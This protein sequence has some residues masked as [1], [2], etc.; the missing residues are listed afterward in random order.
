M[1]SRG[2]HTRYTRLNSSV[3]RFDEEAAREC[4]AYVVIRMDLL[5]GKILK[6]LKN[7]DLD[8]FLF[9]LNFQTPAKL[10][11]CHLYNGTNYAPSRLLPP[12]HDG[13]WDTEEEEEE[14]E[15]E[16]DDDDDSAADPLPRW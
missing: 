13:K 15:E 11:Y 3:S 8:K 1:I 2:T 6:I 12:T 9:N 5:L 10:N 7:L 4:A 14:Q 16:E